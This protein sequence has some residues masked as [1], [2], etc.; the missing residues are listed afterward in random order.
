MKVRDGKHHESIIS[1]QVW[2]TTESRGAAIITGSAVRCKTS[3]QTQVRDGGKA[4]RA[5]N[6]VTMSTTACV[7]GLA[8]C[9][10]RVVPYAV[11]EAWQMHC[12]LGC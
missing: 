9:I 11:D 1:A 6:A 3:W 7:C 8:V 12:V 10:A 5:T 4:H 2:Q